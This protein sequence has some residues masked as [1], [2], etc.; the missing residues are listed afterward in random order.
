MP[1]PFSPN[2]TAGRR[3]I[4]IGAT[5]HLHL[6]GSCCSRFLVELLMTY[7]ILQ[8]ASDLPPAKAKGKRPA[9]KAA[10]NISDANSGS[11]VDK[12]HGLS[13]KITVDFVINLDSHLYREGDGTS[14]LGIGWEAT[15]SDITGGTGGYPN[16][17]DLGCRLLQLLGRKGDFARSNLAKGVPV[18]LETKG[19]KNV[20]VSRTSFVQ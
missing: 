7:Q 11:N 2:K 1:V 19:P 10:P 14:C 13:L 8:T 15:L 16:D 12:S 17:M 9:S 5:P 3:K 6:L 18:S 4:H 20:L